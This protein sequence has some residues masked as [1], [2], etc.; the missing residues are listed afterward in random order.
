MKGPLDCWNG[1]WVVPLRNHWSHRRC[2]LFGRSA[3]ETEGGRILQAVL[4]PPREPPRSTEAQI[5]PDRRQRSLSCALTSSQLTSKT[6]R[7]NNQIA[8]AVLWGI[9]RSPHAKVKPSLEFGGRS[10]VP[11][12][13]RPTRGYERSKRP[14]RDLRPYRQERFGVQN[15]P[16]DV[17]SRS[18]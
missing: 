3:E 5:E 2:R 13:A 17:R 16:G 11:G 9:S 10:P 8:P 12:P 7:A 1:R 4:E 6:T 15:R 14:G 18:W